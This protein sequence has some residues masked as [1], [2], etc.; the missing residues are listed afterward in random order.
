MYGGFSS[1]Q[2]PK[3][4]RCWSRQR[5]E[6]RSRLYLLVR[7]NAPGEVCHRWSD[8]SEEE[9]VIANMLPRIDGGGAPEED[10]FGLLNDFGKQPARRQQR[11]S[12]G[13]QTPGRRGDLEIL[14]P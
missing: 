13:Y 9:Q 8:L 6:V 11:V 2:G 7:P 5:P 1:H 14:W 4:N 10:W 3:Q 12:P